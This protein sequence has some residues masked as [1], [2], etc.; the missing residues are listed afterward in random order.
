MRDFFGDDELITLDDREG[1]LA[2]IRLL[3]AEV[4]RLRTQNDLL[5]TTLRQIADATLPESELTV[6]YVVFATYLQDIARAVLSEWRK[7]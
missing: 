7:R 1:Y 6:R 4:E 2:S 3:R 5:W